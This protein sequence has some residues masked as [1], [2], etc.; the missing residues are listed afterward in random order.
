MQQYR[1]LS[2]ILFF[3]AA[4]HIKAQQPL[5]ENPLLIHSNA[6]LTFN[7]VNGE[8]I[9][10]AMQSI[11]ALSDARV[12]KISTIP[13]GQHTVANTLLA[14]DELMYD[15]TDLSQK[16]GL[17]AGVHTNEQLR[18]AAN[19]ANEELLA[20]INNLYLKEGLYNALKNLAASPASKKM[21]ANQ[22]KYLRETL[23]TFEKNGMKLPVQQQKEVMDINQK[24]AAT[25][26]QFDENIAKYKDSLRF[27]AAQLTGVPEHIRAPWK[28]ADSTYVVNIN[29]PNS[30]AIGSYAHNSDTRRA[31]FVAYNNRAY[32]KN[33]A[34]LDSLFYYRQLLA[35][36]LGFPSY[37]SYVVVDKMAASPDTVW[38]FENELIKKL[39]PHVT[40]DLDELRQLK[41]QDTS[42][43]A[44]SLY[45]WDISYYTQ[46][47]LDKKYQLNNEE[48]R[49]YFEMNNTLQGMFTVYQQLFNIEI[50]AAAHVPTW[51]EKVKAYELFKGGKKLGT[52]YLDLFP[53]P[54]KFTHFATFPISLYRIS[55]G[56]EVLPV[57]AFVGNFADGDAGTP[58]LLYHREVL[59]LFHEFGHLLHSLLARSDIASQGPF[60]LKGDFIE[61]PSQLLENWCW[62]YDALKLFAR[63]YK[64]GAVLS[65]GLFE[66]MKRAKM[67]QNAAN[68]MKYVYVGVLDFTY[69]DKYDSIKHKDITAVS[70]DLWRLMQ[71]PYVP[72]THAICSSPHLN[73][74]GGFYYGYLWS[75]VFA[76]DMFSVFKKNG[77]MNTATG[78]K[79]A[80]EILEKAATIDER[81]MLYNFL[82]R[83]PNTNA[84]FESL[85]L[86]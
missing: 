55:N 19:T 61:A 69:H 70:A 15:L 30:N 79:Y 9:K 39:S 65:P 28:R 47:L 68:Y 57:T 10:E 82:G 12:K 64:T 52:F 26:V 78:V 67:V 18:D 77:V 83:S 56:R 46:Q 2:L 40:T 58:A 14:T 4:G 24:L 75:R 33:L 31:F 53:R 81:Q 45:A 3:L 54:G 44:D 71:L 49:A 6:P 50:R 84:F 11:T 21:P 80:R 23:L 25:G 17:I 41:Q 35:N 36:K 63:H 37:A 29:T 62:E 13:A 27:T 5:K 48:V 32:P 59:I 42:A 86:E 73:S 1:F 66:K 7:N 8:T 72:N 38:R 43:A 60:T 20:Y 16:L 76:Q 74:Y 22:Q 34:V 51:H 85:G